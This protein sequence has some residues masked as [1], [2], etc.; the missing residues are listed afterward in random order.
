MSVLRNMKLPV[1]ILINLEIFRFTMFKKPCP[2]CNK[3][4]SDTKR[5]ICRQHLQ[6]ILKTCSKFHDNIMKK[7]VEVDHKRFILSVF[8][9]NKIWAYPLEKLISNTYYAH[10]TAH[11]IAIILT[12]IL[13]KYNYYIRT[14]IPLTILFYDFCFN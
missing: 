13:A 6:Y 10:H 2:L 1:N 3:T 5:N 11:Y 12:N 4:W 8:P 7:N 9:P 14:E